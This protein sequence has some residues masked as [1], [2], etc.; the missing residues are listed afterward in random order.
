MISF[1]RPDPNFQ[2][3]E[4]VF[5]TGYRIH[6]TV[7]RQCGRKTLIENPKLGRWEVDTAILRRTEPKTCPLRPA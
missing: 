6:A 3:G 1:K 4:A 7:V 5:Q 2:P